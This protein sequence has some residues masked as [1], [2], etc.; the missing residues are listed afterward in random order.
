MGKIA[1]IEFIESCRGK[2][3][4]QGKEKVLDLL[5]IYAMAE[6]KANE[7]AKRAVVSQVDQW[8]YRLKLAYFGRFV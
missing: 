6:T 1:D 7:R 4:R 5:E 3:A 2:Q 8:A